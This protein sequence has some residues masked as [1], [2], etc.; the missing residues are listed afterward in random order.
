MVR[1]PFISFLLLCIAITTIGMP[2]SIHACAMR[3]DLRGATCGLCAGAE[4]GTDHEKKGNGCCDDRIE[5][6][7]TDPARLA[8][9]I[10]L[11]AA[12]CHPFILPSSVIVVAPTASHHSS[13]F[14]IAH[15][16]PPERH[17]QHAYLFNASFLI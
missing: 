2:V 17:G 3:G 4:E 6:D 7:H 14:S 12:L 5:I 13:F 1:T 11:P 8:A 15:S 9:S 10:E 16:P